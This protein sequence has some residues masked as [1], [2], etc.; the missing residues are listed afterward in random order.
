MGVASAVAADD[1]VA[2]SAS[3]GAEPVLELPR[4]VVE[5]EAEQDHVVQGPFLPDVQG[6][7]INAGKKTTL[8]DFDSLPKINGSN[9]RQALAQTPGLVL[10]EESS[11][12]L[13]IGYRGLEPHR[14][15]YTQVLKDG[16]PI[17]ADQFGYPEAYYVPPLETVDRLEFIRGGG[18][19]MYGPQPGGALNYITHRPRTD[20]VLGGG[21]EHTFGEDNTWNSFTYLDGTS[22][23]LGY[24]GYYQRRE[25]DGFRAANSDVDLDSG[26]LKLAL[27]A[28]GASRWF[29]TLETYREEHGEPGGLSQATFAADPSA[30][31]RLYDRFQLDRDA[32]TVTWERDLTDGQFTVNVWAVDYTRS[33]QRQRGG[34]FGSAPAAFSTTTP[35]AAQNTF[36]DEVQEF[37]TFGAQARYRR[38]WGA[39]GRQVFTSGVQLYHTD[40]PRVDRR[41]NV[42]SGADVVTLDSDREVFYAPVFAENLFRVGDLSITPGVRVETYR[43]KVA[44][45]NFN[46]TTGA[47]TDSRSVTDD[48]TVMLYG[49]GLAYDL[50]RSSQLYANYTESY[51]P[52]IFTESVPNTVTNVV[53]GDLA[54]ATSWQTEFG[55]RSQPAAG[56]VLDTSVFYMEFH[57]KIGGSGSATDPLRNIGEIQYRGVESSAAY[58]LLR[59]AGGDGTEQLNAFVNVTLLDAEIVEDA[60]AAIVGNSPQYAPDH[61]VRTGLIYQ[62]GAGL[63]V[64]LL[65]TLVDEAYADDAHTA[66]RAIPA[67]AVW[68][69]TAEY[70]LPR[71]PFTLLGGVNNLLDESYYSRVRNDGIDPAAGRNYY[72][73][74]RAEF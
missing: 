13:S 23:R 33:S 69:L 10:S 36:T 15:Q 2:A 9:Y 51:R 29:V 44:T 42:V 30:T 16:V 70:R 47:F 31:T 4:M 46:A 63:K 72:A 68:D 5:A 12:L 21:T 27:D 64:A 17:H 19:L 49:V 41:R 60:S 39:E 28:E 55:A 3:T 56:L 65:G 53:A 71:T 14:T 57:D 62:R 26:Y 59:L 7:K 18:S 1:V 20:T 22:D 43:Q 50:P 11:P 24:Y 34:G 48:A 54:A 58:D 73:G 61:L 66:N 38:D 37:E 6:V 35:G 74:V 8:L 52:I 45:E 32:A 67:Y 40:S 25:T